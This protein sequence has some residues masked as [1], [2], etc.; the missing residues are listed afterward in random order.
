ML[1]TVLPT[2]T[3]GGFNAFKSFRHSTSDQA[4]QLT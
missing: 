4:F 1:H 3:G 2:F